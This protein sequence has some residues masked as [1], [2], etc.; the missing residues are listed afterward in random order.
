MHALVSCLFL[1]L[2][3]FVFTNMSW[4]TPGPSNIHVEARKLTIL[5]S[6]TLSLQHRFLIFL[7]QQ[8]LMFHPLRTHL[9][10]IP[11]HTHCRISRWYSFCNRD[12]GVAG[13]KITESLLSFSYQLTYSLIFTCSHSF[14]FQRRA[15]HRSPT[16]S[17]FIVL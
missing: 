10:M 3:H 14:F 17:V 2:H 7:T 13:T 11:Q 1:Y 5:F 6:L 12:A 15:I 8:L 4:E 16:P 9:S